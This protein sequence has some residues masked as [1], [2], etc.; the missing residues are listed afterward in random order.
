MAK[1]AA[2]T[3]PVVIR[4]ARVVTYDSVIQRDLLLEDGRIE[5]LGSPPGGGEAGGEAE[6]PDSGGFVN[7]GD[8][9][10]HYGIGP[11]A[12]RAKTGLDRGGGR[13][14]GVRVR[15][16]QM[17]DAPGFRQRRT[18][19]ISRSGGLNHSLLRDSSG[20]TASRPGPDRGAID[21]GSASGSVSSSSG[22]R[23]PSGA[24]VIDARGLIALPG[25]V[26]IHTHGYE[27][28]DFTLGMYDS[29]T[30]SFDSSESTAREGLANYI[31]RMPA[32]GLTSSWLATMA[33]LP[34][35]LQ[36]RLGLLADFLK[37]SPAGSGTRLHG[38]FLEGSF[39]NDKMCGA[40]NPELVLRP[41]N[42]LFDQ[43][44]EAGMVR[45]ALVA[46]ERGASAVGLIRHMKKR[47]VIAGAGH[48]LATGDD[49]QK[50]RKAGMRYMVHFLN[51]PTGSSFKPFFG[52]GAV[53]AALADD[54][55]F[56]ELIPDGYH[57]SPH[58]IRDVISRKGVDRV[59]AI[60]DSMF[61]AGAKG[62]RS[63]QVNG[64]YGNV[65]PDGKYLS[66]A[67]SPTTLFGSCTNMAVA[68]G[69]LLS[70]LT[71]S[72]E[73][74]WVP[75]HEAMA[76]DEALVAVARMA[77]SNPAGM[78]GLDR[79]LGI[80][81]IAPGRAADVVLARLQGRPGNFRLSVQ[82]TFVGGKQV[83]SSR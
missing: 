13:S 28:F 30:D 14:A 82:R 22:G 29:S 44:N 65:S 57:V 56:V 54:K 3:G 25:F 11:S 49:L 34:K 40:M 26:D 68:F 5:F 18:T 32:T 12:L 21:R 58:Y 79:K 59:I 70:W 33:A 77:A 31:S 2:Q 52:G 61:A 8:E 15:D 62:L 64:V 20:A 81:R 80:G 41:E 6:P 72:M 43:I 23:I 75:R 53:E 63:F 19:P 9:D 4:N 35:A 50:A 17:S 51:G 27:G 73:G 37:G 46:P 69:N 42:A 76:E 60:S 39:I 16:E 7:L 78:T 36:E 83:F 47:G 48:T 74:V 71:R 55:L 24:T 66:V 38:A 1:A 67:T 10:E 45:L